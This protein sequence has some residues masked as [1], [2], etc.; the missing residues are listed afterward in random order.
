MPKI[1][2]IHV[3]FI[4]L[5]ME[6]RWLVFQII[7]YVLPSVLWHCWLGDRKGIQLLKTTSTAVFLDLMKARWQKVISKSGTLLL[8]LSQEGSSLKP[9][10]KST[11]AMATAFLTYLGSMVS[12]V[13]S[14]SA[15]MLLAGQQNWVNVCHCSVYMYVHTHTHTV[16]PK[17]RHN[18]H[19][20]IFTKYQSIFKILSLTQ[21][22][23]NLQVKCKMITKDSTT[24]HQHCCTS[25]WNVT[26]RKLARPVCGLEHLLLKDE[27]ARPD[28]TYCCL[29]YVM[30]GLAMFCHKNLM[31]TGSTDLDS[32]INK[33]Q[34][35]LA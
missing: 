25:L 8:L 11:H 20:H 15:L 18:T 26:V 31:I 2:K 10:G 19:A 21:L 33:Y 30:S 12:L 34:T 28:I 22:V 4:K 16:S 29:P 6:Y 32:G 5:C 24:I 7:M 17:M 27:I 14:F 9:E 1:T 3:N 13:S 23:I 35:C